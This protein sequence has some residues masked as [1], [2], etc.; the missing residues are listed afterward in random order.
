MSIP[1]EIIAILERKKTVVSEAIAQSQNQV[2][3][4]NQWPRE[5]GNT[6]TATTNNSANSPVNNNLT[7]NN[8]AVVGTTD[9]ASDL[10]LA[11]N[12][13]DPSAATQ[14]SLNNVN[15]GF[16]SSIAHI[17]KLIQARQQAA[18]LIAP[19]ASPEPMTKLPS[20]AGINLASTAEVTPPVVS[21]KVPELDAAAQELEAALNEGYAT[22]YFGGFLANSE[23]V[24]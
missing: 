24:G 11:K 17:N 13:T 21:A 4:Q 14:P 12:A 22:F 3:S 16:A 2:Q 10:A 7:T 9:L 19:V 8:L 23:K 5:I 1:L 20:A 15:E 18:V 6:T